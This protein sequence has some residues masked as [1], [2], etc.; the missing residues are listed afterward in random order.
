VV[1]IARDVYFSNEM[2]IQVFSSVAKR[3][4]EMIKSTGMDKWFKDN[5]SWEEVLKALETFSGFSCSGC[6][7]GGGIENCEVRECCS[8]KGIDGCWSVINF[9]AKSWFLFSRTISG[10]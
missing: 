2:S 4:L 9:L 8:E 7:N 10:T 1:F 5:F 6:K 3:L